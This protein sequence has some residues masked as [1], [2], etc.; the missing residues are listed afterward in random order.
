M[1]IFFSYFSVSQC[2]VCLN[3]FVILF[4]YSFRRLPTRILKVCLVTVNIF[5]L[6][7][8][9]GQCCVW[10]S[11]SFS[12]LLFMT[13]RFLSFYQQYPICRMHRHTFLF[14]F[15]FASLSEIIIY[16]SSS[17]R[18]HFHHF[19]SIFHRQILNTIFF[20]ASFISNFCNK[21]VIIASAPR[22]LCMDTS[23]FFFLI[24]PASIYQ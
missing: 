22:D 9:I 8:I 2:C 3:V 5:I 19:A 20:S 7:V 17:F 18:I 12:F 1:L 11:L 23:L 10:M 15:Y 13:R 16:M 14:F 24:L 4:Q 21:L 6:Y